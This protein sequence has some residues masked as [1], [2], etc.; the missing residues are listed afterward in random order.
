MSTAVNNVAVRNTLPDPLA[1]AKTKTIAPVPAALP[2]SAAQTLAPSSITS[3]GQPPKLD[4]GLFTKAGVVEKPPV[5][6]TP[7]A[8]PAA[9]SA[10]FVAGKGDVVLDIQKSDSGYDNKIYYSTDNFKTKTFVG[11]DNH[12][13]SVNLGSFAE[14]TKIEFGIDNGNNQFFRTGAASTNFDNF[15]HAQVSKT[16][17][18][19]QIGFE[20]LA[21]GGDRDFNDAIITVRSLPPKASAAEAPPAPVKEPK[22][23]D[24]RSGLAD[25]TNPGQGAGRDNSPNQGTSNPSNTTVAAIVKSAAAAVTAAAKAPVSVASPLPVKA[26]EPAA[27][28]PPVLARPESAKPPVTA[29][30]E[31]AKPLA[32]STPVPAKAPVVA[33]PVSVKPPVV[34]AAEPAKAPVAV[35]A[36]TATRPTVAATLPIPV[37]GVAKPVIS[38]PDKASTAL[39]AAPVSKPVTTTVAATT[40]KDN[41]SGL[42]DGTNP[43]QGAGRTNSPNEGT[44]NPANANTTVKPGLKV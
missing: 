42:G 17:D 37:P 36:P 1:A 4:L 39:P 21:G 11:I 24:N 40:A 5:L 44:N 18:G 28:K 7:A 8:A 30:P 6:N 33:P 34:V 22:V 10:T 26:P 35:P 19:I 14:G 31:T 41:R 43:G 25:G 27:A 29:A 2:A 15:Q 9:G 23:K 20:D 13:G 12:T 3:I 38:A 16:T 32:V